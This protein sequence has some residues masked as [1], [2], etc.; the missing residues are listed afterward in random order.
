MRDWVQV[1]PEPPFS[2]G[3]KGAM[4]L[5]FHSLFSS[6]PLPSR[7]VYL[8]LFGFRTESHHVT[9]A[10]L[11]L[12]LRASVRHKRCNKSHL[13]RKGLIKHLILPYHSPS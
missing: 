1:Q 9:L 2:P 3:K 8:F 11:E 10:G 4:P 7:I 13:R 12:C 5:P 6:P